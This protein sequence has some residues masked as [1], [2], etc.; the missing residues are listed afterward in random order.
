MTLNLPELPG[1][2]TSRSILLAGMGGGFDVFCALPLFWELKQRGLNVHLANYSF[3]DVEG[4]KGGDRLA[5]GLVGVRAHQT[6]QMPYFPEKHLADWL[7]AAHG[8]DQPVWSFQ[9]TGTGPL[10]EHFRL[11]VQHLGVDA[12]VLVDGGVDSLLRGDESQTGTIIEDAIS[13]YCASQLTEVPHRFLL[14]TALGAEQDMA[15]HQVFENIAALTKTGALLGV[16]SLVPQMAAFQEFE[17]AVLQ[18]QSQPFQDPSVINSCLVSAG[19]GDFG[20]V[21]LTAKTRGSRLWISPLMT[22]LWFFD[23]DGVAAQNQF[24]DRLAGTRTFMETLARFMEYKRQVPER[25]TLPLPL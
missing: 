16:C 6:D 20:N 3:S 13:L 24:L 5:P 15:Y 10:L 19:R 1:L 12:L 17:K 8:W 7:L 2:L 11:L 23:L 14:A 9:K 25:V 4:L 18:A 21:H 22:L